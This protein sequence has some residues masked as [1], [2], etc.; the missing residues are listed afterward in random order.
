MKLVSKRLTFTIRCTVQVAF[1]ATFIASCIPPSQS[2]LFWRLTRN[3]LPID[4]VLSKCGVI[5][6]SVWNLCFQNKESIAHLFFSCNY[7]RQVCKWL[8]SMLNLFL[9]I[10]NF[11]DFL[12]L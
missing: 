7:S 8:S 9:E 12:L 6:P 1:R 10:E 3:R 11:E 4:D 2:I 5:I